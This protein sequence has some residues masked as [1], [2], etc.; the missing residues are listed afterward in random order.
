MS[1]KKKYS[2]V[3]MNRLFVKNN[4]SYFI[5]YLNLCFEQC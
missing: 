3:S 4:Y 5:K 2:F 1:N